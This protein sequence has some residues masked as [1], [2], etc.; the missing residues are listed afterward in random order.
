MFRISLSYKYMIRRCLNMDTITYKKVTIVNSNKCG[1][2][3][4]VSVKL[5]ETESFTTRVKISLK[6]FTTHVK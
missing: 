4:I 5:S 1:V 2:F 6:S 3:G